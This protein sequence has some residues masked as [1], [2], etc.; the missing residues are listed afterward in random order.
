MGRL[1][2]DIAVL[3]WAD[4]DR[5]DDAVEVNRWPEK[6]YTLFDLDTERCHVFDL[7]RKIRTNELGDLVCQYEYHEVCQFERGY[8][9]LAS[10]IRG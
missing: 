5:P 8:Q 2:I 1:K 4:P 6:S 7:E 3:K 9:A 10:M